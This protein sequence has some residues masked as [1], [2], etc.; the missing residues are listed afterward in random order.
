MKFDVLKDYDFRLSPNFQVHEFVSPNDSTT[1]CLIDYRLVYALQTLR[2][3]LKA[4]IKITSG[5]RSPR[6]NE[7]VGGSASSQ[8]MF[9]K[10]A[11]IVTTGNINVLASHC[12][13]MELIKG[14]GFYYRDGQ[15]AWIHID[16]RHSLN[17]VEWSQQV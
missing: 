8:H 5:Y 9:G 2:D 14:L 3:E 1:I 7:R 17:R 15:I 11:D 6:H 4:P 12:L 13:S 10:A 16:V